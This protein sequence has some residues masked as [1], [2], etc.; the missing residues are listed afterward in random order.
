MAHA[1]VVEGDREQA[2]RTLR[3]H[4]AEALSIA[5]EPHAD[6]VVFEYGLFSVEDARAVAQFASSA[7][8]A[9]D[10]KMVVI[11][12]T[13]IF[14]EAQNALLKLFEEPPQSVVM[15]LIV[16]SVGQLLP[17]LRSR[18]VVLSSEGAPA[19]PARAF[20]ALTPEAREKFLG[21]L[22][23]RTKGE[24]DEDKQAARGELLALVEDL[25]RE[26]YRAKEKASEKDKE[27]LTAFLADLSAF[28]PILH[29]RSAPLKLIVEH[30]LL[31]YPR[32]LA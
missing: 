21:K 20:I 5:G 4:A 9:G 14:H 8:V 31:V 26:T 1:L 10:A 30:V 29:E 23:D 32:A 15:A 25:I 7:P 2:V 24:K 13:R 12:A 3:A 28:L 22:L 17:T 11:A 18:V 6:F 19:S 27:S 16:P